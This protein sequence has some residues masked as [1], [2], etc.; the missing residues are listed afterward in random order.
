MTKPSR[1]PQLPLSFV[2]PT[3]AGSARP[4]R[5]KRPG[6]GVLKEPPVADQHSQPAETRP[7]CYQLAA[8]D[9]VKECRACNEDQVRRVNGR[10][11]PYVRDGR[12]VW[13][14]RKCKVDE[15]A[16]RGCP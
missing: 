1:S 15:C 14:C 8:Q 4:G 13:T 16:E 3:P 10:C 12:G 5:G 9:G 11:C 7:P 6:K 2:P